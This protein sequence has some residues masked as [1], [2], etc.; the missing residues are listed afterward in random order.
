MVNNL[1]MVII[2]GWAVS[3][4]FAIVFQCRDP[5]TI[6]TTFEWERFECV[7]TLHIYY[8][9][10]V[11]GFITDLLIL[12]SPLPVIRQLQMPLETRIAAACIFLLGAL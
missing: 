7:Q 10:A 3:F 5:R 8:A 6:W 11:S 1:L 12:A 4:F 2:V 9:L